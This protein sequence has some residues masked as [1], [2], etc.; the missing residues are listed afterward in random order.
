MDWVI[1]TKSAFTC[2][3]FLGT[4]TRLSLDVCDQLVALNFSKYFIEELYKSSKIGIFTK[5]FG[6]SSI[7]AI[8]GFFEPIREFISFTIFPTVFA[9]PAFK[10]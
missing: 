7:K 3:D 10:Q 6:Y 4:W 2:L 5:S 9:I 1:I 8:K